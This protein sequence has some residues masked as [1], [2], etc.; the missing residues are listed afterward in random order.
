[1]LNDTRILS[2]GLIA[3]DLDY[4]GNV[5]LTDLAVLLQAFGGSDAGDLDGDGETTL[6]DLAM[7]LVRFGLRCL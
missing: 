1:M 2:L 6:S 4:D 7:L 5:G 3:G